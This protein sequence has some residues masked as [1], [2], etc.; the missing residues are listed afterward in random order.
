VWA[1]GSVSDANNDIVKTLMN[2]DIQ[3]VIKGKNGTYEEFYESG[4][5]KYTANYNHG[6]RISPSKSFY[7]TGQLQS[8]NE[9]ND[10]GEY[11][12]ITTYQENGAL[13]SKTYYENGKPHG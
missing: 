12:N 10:A 5:L 7:E 1:K 13:E 4:K 6:K 2:P 8:V 11:T 9:F 3:N